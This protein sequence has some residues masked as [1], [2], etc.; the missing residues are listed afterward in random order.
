MLHVKKSTDC[1]KS[2]GLVIWIGTAIAFHLHSRLIRFEI[3][4]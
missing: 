3:Q 2:V 1:M 4:I